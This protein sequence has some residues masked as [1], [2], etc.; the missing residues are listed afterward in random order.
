METVK[1]AEN[2]L[3]GQWRFYQCCES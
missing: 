3:L 1:E 2:Y